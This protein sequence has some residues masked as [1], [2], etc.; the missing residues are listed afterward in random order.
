MAQAACNDAEFIELWQELGSPTLVADRLGVSERSV[1][2]RRNRLEGAGFSLPTTNDQRA[3]V[4][5]PAR[6]HT[7]VEDGVAIV[8]SDPH[9]HPGI[10]S[11]AHRALVQFV[12]DMQP[13]LVICNGDAFDGSSISRFP[14]IGWDT[15]PTVKEEL[16]AV[17]LAL[18]QIEDAAIG[19][20][21][22]WPLGNHDARFETFL[23]NK[24]PE[25]Q[26][27]D[28]FTLKDRF[29]RWTPCWSCWINNDVVC[30]HSIRNGVNA[31]RNNTLN[32]GMTTV[33]GHLHQLKVT[34]L[35][36]YR[37]RRYGVDTGTLAD[38]YGPQFVDYTADSP[39]DWHSGFVVLTFHAG[40]L[41]TPEIVE[42]FDD[43]HV[44]FRGRVI[45]V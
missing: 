23:A 20:E 35:S 6:H 31:A 37:G 26:G 40:R 10:I 43:D 34:P 44:M 45:A 14:R 9:Y 29:A 16:E 11:T 2:A 39:V 4:D 41:L 36:D 30:K 13:K 15:K 33:T 3:P 42:K 5:H 22:V 17:D 19:A 38:P 27:V 25:Y 28:G 8:F 1:Y 32:A 7:Q 21:L 12:Q 24:V 18:T